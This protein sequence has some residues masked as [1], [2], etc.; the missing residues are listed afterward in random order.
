MKMSE[1]GC[2]LLAGWEGVEL[3]EYLDVAGLPTI[4]VGHLLTDQEKASGTI[5]IG[6]ECFNYGD[7]LTEQQVYDLLAQDLERF[8][9]SVEEKV[10]VD[11]AQ[12]QFDALVSFSFNVG[13]SAFEGSTLL[14]KLNAGDYGDVPNQLRR[15]VKADGRT[16][17]GLVNRREN[18]IKLWNNGF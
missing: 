17:Q 7:G 8:E 1:K 9:R 5:D 4:G 16:V 11:L 14:K 2:K 13:I 18:E 6:T 3:E 10:T 12:H 15:W